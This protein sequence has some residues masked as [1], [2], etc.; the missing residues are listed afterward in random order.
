[1]E[2]SQILP[3]DAIGAISRAQQAVVVGDDKQLPPTRFFRVAA[4]A[5]EDEE[6][7]ELPESILDLCA[8]SGM[9]RKMLIWHYRSRHEALIA[10][11]NKHLYN[12]ELKTFPSPRHNERVVELVQVPN[13]VYDRGARHPVNRV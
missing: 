1:D 13:G 3:A 12:G 7:E 5:L 6:D 4:P 8:R 10:F 11:S 9:P 2:A